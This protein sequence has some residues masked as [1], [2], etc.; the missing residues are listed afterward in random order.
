MGKTVTKKR[1]HV[2][3]SSKFGGCRGWAYFTEDQN[4]FDSISVRL[5]RAQVE[6][7]NR[8][9]TESATTQDR[10]AF[11]S[12]TTHTRI[13][14]GHLVRL[15]CLELDVLSDLEALAEVEEYPSLS[16]EVPKLLE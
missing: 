15:S 9:P 13:V 8:N 14:H 2:K 6:D 1:V 11:D 16:H 12:A 10:W 7:P 5:D 3:K 4:S